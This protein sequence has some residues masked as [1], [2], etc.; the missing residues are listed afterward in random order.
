MKPL[1]KDALKLPN[2][3]TIPENCVR[4]ITLTRHAPRVPKARGN[5]Y[6]AENR[7]A[8]PEPSL[9]DVLISCWFRIQF[10]KPPHDPRPHQ[11]RNAKPLRNE[12]ETNTKRS[13]MISMRNQAAERQYTALPSK[14]FPLS[15]RCVT[16]RALSISRLPNI[17]MGIRL[18]RVGYPTRT[19]GLPDSAEW[20]TRFGEVGYPTLCGRIADSHARYQTIII[21]KPAQ[22]RHALLAHIPTL[23]P[24]AHS[25]RASGIRQTE[26]P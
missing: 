13:A 5:L 7:P 19:S 25:A 17:K 9:N 22:S 11:E 20:A 3:R 6:F 18:A 12:Y 26:S 23:A 8:A 14:Q 1:G 24:R 21:K 16:R 2:A 15:Y 4:P 10:V